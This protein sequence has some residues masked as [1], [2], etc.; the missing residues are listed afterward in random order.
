MLS[1]EGDFPKHNKQFTHSVTYPELFELRL[2][3]C[4]LSWL[5]KNVR[6][7]QGLLGRWCKL[8]HHDA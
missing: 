6:I 4:Q 3:N 2:Q 7:I 1:K 8:T 5:N